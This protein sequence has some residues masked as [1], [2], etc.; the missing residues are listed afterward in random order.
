MSLFQWFCL[1]KAFP[2][3]SFVT[4]EITFLI[5]ETEPID[6]ISLFLLRNVNFCL[7]KYTFKYWMRVL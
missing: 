6:E 4:T 1:N 7:A 3:K 2:N 5:S